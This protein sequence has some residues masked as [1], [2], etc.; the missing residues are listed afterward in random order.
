M[1]S[2]ASCGQPLQVIVAPRG[3]LMFLAG[4]LRVLI[5]LGAKKVV[6]ARGAAVSLI[7]AVLKEQSKNV[8]ARC[9][10]ETEKFLT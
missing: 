3:A 2:A 9:Q 4:R 8:R 5:V 7:G 1:R 10:F 6:V